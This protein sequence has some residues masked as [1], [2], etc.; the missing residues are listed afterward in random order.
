MTVRTAT[1]DDVEGVARVAERSWTDDYPDILTRDTAEAAV[2]EWYAPER[3]A[4]ELE[5]DR[6]VLLV[7]DRGGEVVGFAHATWEESGTDGYIL[8]LYVHPDHR[9]EGLGRALL[10]RARADLSDHGIERVNAMVLAAN[11][12]GNAFYERFGFR[13]RPSDAPGMFSGVRLYAPIN[14]VGQFDEFLVFQGAS[15]FRS[16]GAG[17]HYGLSAR[18]LAVDTGEPR[19]EEFPLFR[20]FWLE[21][22]QAR[23]KAV[24]VHA[25]LDGRSVVGA[26]TFRI[27]P[28]PETRM[29][30]KARLFPRRDIK[31]MGLAPLTSMFLF[32]PTN[33]H[34][35]D[36]YRSRVH[37]SD[38]LLM[39]TGNDRW[40]W[41]PLRNPREL[42]FS[43]FQDE[44][45]HGFGLQQRQ[46]D[47]D[48]YHDW[49]ARY[50]RRPSAWVEPIGDWGK[51]SIE[52]AEIPT[53]R[54]YA[55]IHECGVSK[56]LNRV[57]AAHDRKC[58]ASFEPRHENPIRAVECD[59]EPA[60]LQDQTKNRSNADPSHL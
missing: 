26:Y 17:Q 29:H 53:Q 35:F 58:W 5:A 3:I 1:E 47:L 11:D 7:A 50:D 51:G 30:I 10:E 18:G 40:L 48:Q 36:D 4:E 45:P 59:N 46:R 13:A 34:R 52:L 60:N 43:F 41:R 42:Q 8:R 25:L 21:R 38:G 24:T 28:G 44:S 14:S 22:P 19:G 54:E 16:L 33:R 37:D 57:E 15:Y 27:T 31:V 39:R 32:G 49:E 2:N 23:A 20:T 55:D 56:G 12:P 9:G 6:T